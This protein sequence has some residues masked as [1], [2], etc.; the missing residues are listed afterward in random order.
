MPCDRTSKQE[1]MLIGWS[2]DGRGHD[3][4]T[5]H[6]P[7]QTVESQVFLGCPILDLAARQEL[8]ATEWR[9]ADRALNTPN[10]DVLRE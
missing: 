3:R 1:I 5:G 6:R 7:A 9:L 4:S 8:F 2:V 10:S